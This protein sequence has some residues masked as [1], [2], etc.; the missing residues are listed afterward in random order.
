[1]KKGNLK[2]SHLIVADKDSNHIAD[3]KNP[4][5]SIGTTTLTFP[6]GSKHSNHP[7]EIKPSGVGRHV[8]SFVKDSMMYVWENER[9]KVANKTLVKLV[10]SEKVRVARNG[11]KTGQDT[12]GVLVVDT[13]VVDELVAVM[14]SLAV[15][16][17]TEIYR[18]ERISSGSTVHLVGIGIQ[19]SW[20]HYGHLL[21]GPEMFVILQH[22]RCLIFGSL[23]ELRR[24]LI[25]A[26]DLRSPRSCCTCQI[27]YI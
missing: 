13:G 11:Q 2:G 22:R 25:F 1:L 10:E 8:E 3:W 14:T 15:L 12:D 7:I 18:N 20:P 17:H 19:L 9:V 5:V 6:E 24:C 21:G 16:R 26:T 27:V 4:I 23:L